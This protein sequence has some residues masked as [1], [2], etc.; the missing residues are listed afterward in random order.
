MNEAELIFSELMNC[1]RARL[2]L[3][4][5]L[6]PD[7]HKLT[8]AA[9]ILKRRIRGEPVQYILGETEF[10]GLR[11]KVNAAVFIPRPETELL[12]EETIKLARGQAHKLRIL[13]LGTGS[14]CI[15]ISLAK[16]INNS[17][18]VA[19]DISKEAITVAKNNAEFNG[20]VNKINFINQDFFN[21]QPEGCSLRRNYFDIIVSNPPYIPENEIENLQPEIGYE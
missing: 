20:V 12:V 14:G 19:V 3:D 1:D 8:Q 9:G 7:K 5:D 6:R 18:I 10:M 4:R 17:K 15:A 2:Y 16:F 11:F 21:L 13:D